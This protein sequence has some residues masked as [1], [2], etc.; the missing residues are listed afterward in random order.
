M[1]LIGVSDVVTDY[2][3]KTADVL[4]LRVFASL[5]ATVAA[6]REAGIPVAG[7]LDDLLLKQTDVVVECTPKGFGARN[8]G[9]YRAARVK[10]VLQGGEKHEVT[11]HPF[12]AEANYAS[13]LGRDATPRAWCRATRQPLFARSAH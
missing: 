11:G 4:G 10:A 13:A 5:P 7:A 9:R 6:M 12:V 3:I 2:R 1:E 8:L